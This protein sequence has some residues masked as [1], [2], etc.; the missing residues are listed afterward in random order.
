MRPVIMSDVNRAPDCKSGAA[1]FLFIR[2]IDSNVR[3]RYLTPRG[4]QRP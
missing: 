3:L 4:E 1:T 2:V